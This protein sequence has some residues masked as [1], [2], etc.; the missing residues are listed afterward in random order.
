VTGHDDPTFVKRLFVWVKR[1]PRTKMLVYH[2]DF[3]TVNPF[4]IQN[5]PASL[6]VFQRRIAGEEFPAYAFEP[7]HLPPSAGVPK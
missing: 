6:G 7:P 4:R 3:G 5:F 1:H 2:Q